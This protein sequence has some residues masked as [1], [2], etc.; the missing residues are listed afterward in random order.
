MR[1]LVTGGLGFIGSH[2]IEGLLNDD[3]TESIINIDKG[4]YASNKLFKPDDPRYKLWQ[5]DIGST[6]AIKEL[7]CEFDIVVNFASHSHVDN[8]I[9]K[10]SDFLQNNIECFFN[11]LNLCSKWQTVGKIGKFVHISTDEV[12]G[13][14]EDSIYDYFIE[15]SNL[16][17]SSPYSASKAS[18]EMFIHM[19]RKMFGLNANI[20]RLCNNYGP[21]QF[22]EKFIPVVIKNILNNNK[23]PV[24]G[25]GK[26]RREWIY[27]KDAV[28]RI[29]MIATKS[30]DTDDYCIGSGELKTNLDIIKTINDL[31]GRLSDGNIQFVPDRVGHDRTY[32]MDSRK[33]NYQYKEAQ[34]GDLPLKEG[35]KKTLHYFEKSPTHTSATQGASC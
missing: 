14:T 16:R 19:A 29:K 24:Y 31:T 8:S 17:P 33:F 18:Q 35:L 9:E 12:F 34:V 32:K 2:F 11:F 13:D 10:P 23:I 30:D 1:Y 20:L 22:E 25:D 15:G 4:T 7:D 21:R 3:T 5:E 26:Q 28:K 6:D 27:V